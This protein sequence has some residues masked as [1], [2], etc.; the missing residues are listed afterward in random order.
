MAYLPIKRSV[1]TAYSNKSADFE[2]SSSTST[3]NN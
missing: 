1:Y 3:F 2:K